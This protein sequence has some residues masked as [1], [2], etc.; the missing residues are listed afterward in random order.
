M[1]RTN[2]N[3]R[4]SAEEKNREILEDYAK[5][6]SSKTK[7]QGRKGSSKQRPPTEPTIGEEQAQAAIDIDAKRVAASSEALPKEARPTPVAAATDDLDELSWNIVRIAT[8]YCFFHYPT[9][10][11]AGIPVASENIWVVPVM[12]GH[13][14]YGTLGPFGEISIDARTKTV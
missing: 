6:T 12:L 3:R 13:P 11:G 8:K 2:K 9:L 5:T 1:K 14:T 4:T 10:F 7:S